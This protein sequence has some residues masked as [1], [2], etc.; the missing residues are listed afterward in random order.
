[1]ADCENKGIGKV[2]D[3]D[4]NNNVGELNNVSDVDISQLQ[5]TSP[6]VDKM[7][8][9]DIYSNLCH[10]V[11][12]IKIAD[13]SDAFL[14]SQIKKR[15]NSYCGA[16]TIVTFK[17]WLTTYT[18]LRD[19]YYYGKDMALGELIDLGMQRARKSVNSERPDD[20]IVKLIDRIDNGTISH[21]NKPSVID[22]QA[23]G[24]MSAE[25]LKNMSKLF[26]ALDTVIEPEPPDGEE[27]MEDGSE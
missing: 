22:K 8:A 17:K 26:N 9:D 27:E 15:F 1:M 4:F 2:V 18:T 13:K 25:T 24:G 11:R 6:I 10:L 16:L 3:S 7:I 21:K 5:Y 20:F 23:N 19:S 12:S 14:V